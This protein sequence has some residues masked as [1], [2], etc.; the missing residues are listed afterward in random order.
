M[1]DELDLAQIV[2]AAESAAIQRLTLYIPSRDR[3]GKEFDPARWVEE[4][5]RLLSRIGGGA[6]AMPPVDGAWLN[7]ETSELIREK[8][9]LA[10]TFI[11]PD[12]FEATLHELRAFLHRIGRETNQGEVVFEFDDRLFK[13][14][15]YDAE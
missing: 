3:N 15:A 7:P 5:L 4:A 1:T 11:D 10:Y 14:V 2:G 8:V 9:V 13:I 12:K 6:T